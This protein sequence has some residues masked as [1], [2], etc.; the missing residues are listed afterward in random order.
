MVNRYFNFNQLLYQKL[1][2]EQI[3]E[4]VRS[5]FGLEV[6]N[7][8]EKVSLLNPSQRIMND[9]EASFDFGFDFDF[10]FNF[11][12]NPISVSNRLKIGSQ[13]FH[14]QDYS[15]VGPRT[16]NYIISYQQGSFTKYG[17]I[18]Y[19]LKIRNEIFVA[20]NTLQIF[21][22]LYE[23]TGA[24]T[25]VCLT[26]LRNEGAFDKYFCD[27]RVEENLIFIHSS[28][29]K[30]KCIAKRTNSTT[31]CLSELEDDPGHN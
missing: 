3:I 29:V 24:R 30:T 10:D 16:S 4:Y 8:K 28:Q 13:I 7:E 11:F 27:C 15:R 17:V 14:S 18:K 12:R 20:I 9:F 2:N 25:S 5:A 23:N 21:G 19:F 22:S 1:K 6:F 31:F 26:N